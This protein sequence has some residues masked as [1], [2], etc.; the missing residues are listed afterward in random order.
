MSLNIYN[1]LS[2]KREVFEPADPNRVTVY[3]CGPT[4]YNHAHIGNARPAVAFDVLVRVLRHIYP[5]V[6]YAR[7]ITDVDDKINAA[8]LEE[9]VPIGTITDRYTKIYHQ[10][11][12]ALG[13]LPPDVEPKA[14]DHIKEMQQMIERLIEKGF[15]IIRNSKNEIIKGVDDIKLK[16]NIKIIL[17]DGETIA[18]IE[19]INEKNYKH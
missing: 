11:M 19:E 16:D 4:V 7:N 12:G 5:G 2:G 15:A 17:K 3:V 6:V 13:V 10:D 8:A 1:T 9:G 14:T 18:S